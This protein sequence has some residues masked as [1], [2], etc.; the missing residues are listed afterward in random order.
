MAQAFRPCRVGDSFGPSWTTHWFRVS[1][2][3]PHDYAALPG[4]LLF[5]WDSG[6]EA[7]VWQDGEPMQGITDNRNEYRLDPQ[8]T[9]GACVQCTLHINCIANFK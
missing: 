8:V 6:C 2:L 5:V 9:G 4:P 3:V 1:A 7:M